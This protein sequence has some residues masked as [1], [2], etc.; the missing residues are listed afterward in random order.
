MPSL[1]VGAFT[2]KG[3]DLVPNG[4]FMQRSIVEFKHI[5]GGVFSGLVQRIR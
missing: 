1:A 5:C 2:T 3:R 4:S